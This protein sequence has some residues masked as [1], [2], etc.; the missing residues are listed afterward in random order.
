MVPAGGSPRPS[1]GFDRFGQSVVKAVSHAADRWLDVG[2]G[3]A[4]GEFYGYVLRFTIAVMN[5]AAAM[6]RPTIVRRLLE[7]IQHSCSCQPRPP[8]P[9]REGSAGR[10]RSYRQATP[11]PT[12]VTDNRPRGPISSA[13]HGHEPR[14]KIC[15]LSCSYRLH[16]LM[17]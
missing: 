4:F 3:K 17:S 9:T 5:Q 13:P 10:S 11:P 16:L 7:S 6:D 14:V 8:S 2:F 1:K 12:S 15:S